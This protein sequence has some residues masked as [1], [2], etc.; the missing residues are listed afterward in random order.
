MHICVCVYADPLSLTL[1][2]VPGVRHADVQAGCRDEEAREGVGTLTGTRFW[3]GWVG[4]WLR[5]VIMDVFLTQ[6]L[7]L[8]VALARTNSLHAHRKYY[9]D[10]A[11]KALERKLCSDHGQKYLRTEAVWDNELEIDPCSESV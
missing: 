1:P 8:T 2:L 9:F 11:E 10:V 7:I 4:L 5:V 3:A 6:S